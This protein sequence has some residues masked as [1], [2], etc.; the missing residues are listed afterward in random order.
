MSAK[1]LS[2]LGI[3]SKQLHPTLFVKGQLQE[4]VDNAAAAAASQQEVELTAQGQDS[5]KQ[6]GRTHQLQNMLLEVCAFMVDA[7]VS[8]REAPERHNANALLQI[9]DMGGKQ[10][11]TRGTHC[12]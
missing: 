6:W 3:L 9:G 7:V 1:F 4:L 12:E 10:E 2:Q 11:M 8:E 5:A